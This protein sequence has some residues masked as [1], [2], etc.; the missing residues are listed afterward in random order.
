MIRRLQAEQLR[1]YLRKVVLPFSAHYR[2]LFAEQ[3][4]EADSIQHLEDLQQL[5]F[6]TKADLQNTAAEP[7]RFK[8]FIVVPDQKVLARRPGT[9]WRALTRGRQSVKDEFESEF[10]PIFVTFTTGR[11][12]EPTPFFFTQRDLGHLETAGARLI[13]VCAARREERLLN[14][15]PFS[16]HLA[17]WLAHYSGTAGGVLVLSSGGG[18]VLGTDGH[19][20]HLRGCV[21]LQY[22]RHRIWR[23]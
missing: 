1:E 6:T 16:P 12:A 13:Q 14:I 21:Q 17:F 22:W 11:S 23:R 7:Q 5:P 20:R 3:G 15:F 10:R 4:L 2:R 8:D 18:K 19:V 9:I